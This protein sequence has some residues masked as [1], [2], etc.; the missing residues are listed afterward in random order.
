M[1]QQLFLCLLEIKSYC[2]LQGFCTF[3]LLW[4]FSGSLS[5]K[6]ST[7]A[8]I[9]CVLLEGLLAEGDALRQTGKTARGLGKDG[10]TL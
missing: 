9:L 4:W 7:A 10:G 3:E 2:T 1:W 6:L 8:P 5:W